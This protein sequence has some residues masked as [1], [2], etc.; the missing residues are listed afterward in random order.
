MEKSERRDR[1]RERESAREDWHRERNAVAILEKRGRARDF[2]SVAGDWR[3]RKR[4][5]DQAQIA[6]RL[7]G[8]ICLFGSEAEQTLPQT[9]RTH[10]YQTKVT[11][12]ILNWEFGLAQFAARVTSGFLKWLITKACIFYM[13]AMNN[14]ISLANTNHSIY[15]LTV[16]FE[17]FCFHIQSFSFFLIAVITEGWMSMISMSQLV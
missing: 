4:V 9:G 2:S 7:C 16:S 8:I 11:V 1:E 5:R 12:C 17:I 10:C 13:I 14:P 6:G 3:S 15:L